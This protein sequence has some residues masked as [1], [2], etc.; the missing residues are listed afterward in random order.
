MPDDDAGF[1]RNLSGL[2]T[3]YVRQKRIT[4]AA[5]DPETNVDATGGS[6]RY[7]FGG[8]ELTFEDLRKVKDIRDSGGQIA[9]LLH[10]KALLNFGEGAEV[11]VEDDEETTELVDGEELTLSEWLE[12]EAFPKL[13]L[14]VLDLGEDALSYPCAVGEIQETVTGDFKRA[15]PAE[16]WTIMPITN[17]YG[18]VEAYHQQTKAPGGGYTEKTL[19]A[20]D[21]WH[22][23]VNKSSARD[24]TGISEVLRNKDEIQAFKENEH[25]INNAIELHGFPQRHV[26]VGREEGAP[27]SD[28]DLK[29]VRTV[30]DPRTSDANTMYL[31]GRDVEVNTLEAQVEELEE[32]RGT[33]ESLEEQIDDLQAHLESI[34]A[35]V[36][37]LVQWRDQLGEMFTGGEP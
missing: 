15:L 5:G 21:L 22:I 36:T 26:K 18:E 25:A 11:H 28:T 32:L 34:D 7:Q 6:H 10:S 4:L 33:S 23:V 29:R 9:T 35:E 37:E 1:F 17:E 30:F 27:V 12:T 24:Q 16:P 8:Q 19:P 20:E 31:T 13:D 3:E 2:A 14:L